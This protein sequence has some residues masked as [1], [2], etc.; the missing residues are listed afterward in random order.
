MTLKFFLNG[1]FVTL[2]GETTIAPAPAQF[3]HSKRLHTIDAIIEYFTIQLLKSHELEDT[4]K[5]LPTEV[6]YK[7]KLSDHAKIHPVFHISQLK[8]F[9]GVPQDQYMPLP[10]TMSDIRPIIWPMEILQ[11]RTIIK[12]SQKV[13]QVLMQWDQQHISEA[14]WEDAASLQQKFPLFNLEDKVDFEVEGIVMRIFFLI[15][16]FF[17][18]KIK[19]N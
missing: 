17:L 5:E 10:L 19:N 7:L 8:L 12:G 16:Q 2:T 6:A 14:T 9:K 11:A 13:H 4:F 18:K 3:H 1:K 15:I